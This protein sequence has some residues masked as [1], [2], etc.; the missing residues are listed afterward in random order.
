MAKKEK[1]VVLDYDDTIG[2]FLGSLCQLHNRIHG[3]HITEHVIDSWDFNDVE[4]KDVNGNIVR[5]SELE[6][7]LKEY[8]VQLYAAM[9]LLPDSKFAIDTMKAIGYKVFILTARPEQYAKETHFNIIKN[10]LNC[11]EVIF[12]WDKAKVLKQLAKK[13]N[14]KLFAD[15]NVETIK[16]VH[17]NCRIGTVCLVNKKH[18]LDVEV[19]EEIKRIGSIVD[20]IKYLK[21]VNKK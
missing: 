21:K 18:N 4:I 19:D 10:D 15:D 14:I 13:Y 8:E 5:G 16:T 12:D 3:T 9:P 17:E 2:S 7:T 6:Q 1:I 11:D 20:C